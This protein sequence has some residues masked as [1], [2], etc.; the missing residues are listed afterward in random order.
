MAS[1]A[2]IEQTL[3][4]T[5][6]EDFGEWDSEYSSPAQPGYSGGLDADPGF[7]AVPMPPVQPIKLQAPAARKA[8]VFINTA[9]PLQASTAVADE[10][11]GTVVRKV[12][13]MYEA[14]EALIQSIRTNI[15]KTVKQKPPSSNWRMVAAASAGLTLLLLVLI[16][17]YDHGKLP[18][19]G[20]AAQPIA[21]DT[22]PDAATL[23][24]SPALQSNTGH[25]HVSVNMQHTAITKPSA[26]K[27]EVIQPQTQSKMMQE[28]LTAPTR[29]PHDLKIRTADVAPSL[30]GLG[31]TGIQGQG[32]N[33]AMG[34]IFKGQAPASVK[35]ATPKTVTVSEGIAGGLLI[36]RTVPVYPEIAKIAHVS[37]TVVL[38][39]TISKT[40]RIEDLKVVSGPAMLKQAA[41]NAV[42]TWRFKPYKLNNDPLEVETIIKV[43]FTLGD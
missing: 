33:S 22:Q 38:K 39:A 31:A 7:V 8:S 32:G 10:M 30:L 23:N 20:D 18:M 25:Q 19:F 12:T 37:G 21:T 41:L 11:H 4:D 26:G 17:L 35:L 6:P 34:S 5:L 16:P 42:R 9:S 24:Q 28:Q 1:T 2:K 43:V 40:G 14:D 3:P 15:A 36:Q 13:A 29:I 27:A